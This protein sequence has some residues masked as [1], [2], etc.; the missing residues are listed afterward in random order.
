MA[1]EQALILLIIRFCIF[2]TIYNLK[3]KTK[4]HVQRVNQNVD[5]KMNNLYDSVV[6]APISNCRLAKALHK[7]G[8]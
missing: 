7:W 8:P 6:Q 5:V 4:L 3:K 1:N 2:F